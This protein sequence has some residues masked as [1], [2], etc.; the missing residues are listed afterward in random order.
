MAESKKISQLDAITVVDAD[1]EFVLNSSE[2]SKKIAA[3][4]LVMGVQDMWIPAA[5]MRPATTN[6]C[7]AIADLETQA[8]RPDIQTLDFHQSTQQYAQFSVGMPKSWNSSTVTAKFYW[9]H[10]TAVDTY[11]IWGI[12]AVAVT[13]NGT[14]DVDY[15]AAQTVTDQFHNTAEDLAITAATSAIAIDG[16]GD[17]VFFQVYR[18]AD[19]GGDSTDSTVAKLIGVKISYTTSEANDA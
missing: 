18:D 13:D 15:G 6:G 3:S 5:A 4:N 9:T 11:V 14:I 1:D 8:T 10:A 19:A 17:L 12:Q 7:T 2:E 16:S